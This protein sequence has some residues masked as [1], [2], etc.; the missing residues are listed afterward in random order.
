[1]TQVGMKPPS[2]LAKLCDF[3]T[4]QTCLFDPKAQTTGQDVVGW[5]RHPPLPPH[6]SANAVPL[7][8]QSPGWG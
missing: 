7:R 1:M 6:P 2:Q 8:D 3:Q 4:I 5:C